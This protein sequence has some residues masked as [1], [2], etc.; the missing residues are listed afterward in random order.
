MFWDER[1]ARG[2]DF[3]QIDRPFA[4]VSLQKP[5]HSGFFTLIWSARPVGFGRRDNSPGW[6]ELASD[7]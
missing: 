3:R 1:L 7:Q 6:I 4:T 5:E 2:L